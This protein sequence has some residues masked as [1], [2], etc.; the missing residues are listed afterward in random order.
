MWFHRLV[1]IGVVAAFLPHVRGKADA[2][3]KGKIA[4][5]GE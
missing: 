1:I 5:K 3:S 2:R 4:Y